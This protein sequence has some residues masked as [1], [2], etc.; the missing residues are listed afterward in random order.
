M[1][2]AASL[3]L[4]QVTSYL[5]LVPREY[6]SGERQDRGRILRS[7]H[8]LVQSL[9]VQ[10]AW[11]LARSASPDTAGLRPWALAITRRRGTTIA[12]VALARR[13]AR[14]LDATWRDESESHA[15]RIRTTQ[16]DPE[17][18]TTREASVSHRERCSSFGSL[19]CAGTYRAPGER[20]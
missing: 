3:E 18:I 12:M 13:V 6:S 8:P 7:A 20:V 4:S 17:T 10:A 11:R 14:I 1:T 2:S 19:S 9:L 5:G 16:F 15:N